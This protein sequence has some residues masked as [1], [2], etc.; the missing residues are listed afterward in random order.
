MY[1]VTLHH[2]QQPLVSSCD[3][4]HVHFMA[5]LSLERQETLGR[6]RGET[7]DKTGLRMDT[8]WDPQDSHGA[9]GQCSDWLSHQPPQFQL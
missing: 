2:C 6:E 4:T 9:Y 8:N 3:M 5:I 7:R 1:L